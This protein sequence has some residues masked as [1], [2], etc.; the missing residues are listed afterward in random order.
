[1]RGS[2]ERNEHINPTTLEGQDIMY[3]LCSC[4]R[5][6]SNCGSSTCLR[7]REKM[8][9]SISFTFPGRMLEILETIMLPSRAIRDH[10]YLHGTTTNTGSK[11]VFS[12]KG[13]KLV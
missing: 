5:L 12:A 11:E 9:S 13:E 1:M 3:I 6:G 10:I 2:Q 7:R 8:H 4:W